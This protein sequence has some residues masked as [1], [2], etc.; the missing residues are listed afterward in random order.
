MR[1]ILFIGLLF[2]SALAF[3]Q[4]DS[5]KRTEDEAKERAEMIFKLALKG[6]SFESL[7]VLY[8]E[9]KGT[10]K[11]GGY[12]GWTNKGSLVKEFEEVAFA[13]QPGEISVPVKSEFGFHIIQLIGKTETAIHSRHILIRFQN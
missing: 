6:E 7:A 12:L 2:V 8:S 11:A 1:N 10:A 9:D 4:Q 3:S 5:T 13:M